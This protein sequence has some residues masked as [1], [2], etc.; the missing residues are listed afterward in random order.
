[1]RDLI[2]LFGGHM[3]SPVPDPYPVYA[4]LRQTEPVKQMQFPLGPTFMVSRYDDAVR[5]L[6]D[7][8]LFSSHANA[9]GIGMVMGRT[10]IEMDGPEH[11]L[12]RSLVSMRFVRRALEGDLPATIESIAHAM[13]DRFAAEG[14]ADLVEQLAKTFPLRVIAHVIGVPIDDFDTFQRWSLE[15]IGFTADP[16]RGFAAASALVEFLRPIVEQRRAEPREDL[17]SMLVHA[18]VEDHRL[19]D[20]EVYSFLKLLLPA[21]AETTSRLIASTLFALLTH[22]QQLEEG[23][24]D[25][26]QLKWAI[27]ETL[28]W[29]SPVQ[30]ASRNTTAPTT[31]AGVELQEN[32]LI[33]VALGS[34]N[35]DES[36]YEEPDRFDMHRRAEDHLAFGFGQH[37]CVGSHLA[38]LEARTALNAIL[39]RLPGLRLRP[40]A[41]AGVVGMAFRSPPSL[42]VRFDS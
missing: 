13:I 22:P 35:R 21:G 34:G 24:A 6:K 41:D 20:E 28:R 30:F 15:V 26:A 10:I 4:R 39:D 14:K 38:R 2:D 23:R 27:E 16:P 40:G 12:H 32:A 5:I 29:E 9:R 17:L 7:D 37:F 36:H 1:M 25:R 3:M 8:R 11:R 18:E 33:L 31:V 19:S 42:P